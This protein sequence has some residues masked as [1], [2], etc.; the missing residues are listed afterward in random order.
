LGDQGSGFD[1]SMMALQAITR[2]EVY[3][4]T[5]KFK[6]FYALK[7]IYDTFWH[8]IIFATMKLS[9]FEILKLETLKLRL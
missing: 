2:A 3:S 5:L 6:F 1:I 9:N 7:Y 8:F 4:I